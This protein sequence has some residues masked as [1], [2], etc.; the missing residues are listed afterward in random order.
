MSKIVGRDLLLF[1]HLVYCFVCKGCYCCLLCKYLAVHDRGNLGCSFWCST[2]DCPLR[3]TL[4]NLHL[5]YLWY[6][7][8]KSCSFSRDGFFQC[9]HDQQSFQRSD[10]LANE[11]RIFIC[12]FEVGLRL[13]PIHIDQKWPRKR[14]ERH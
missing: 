8:D 13:P 4:G 9:F 10:L 11:A 14:C 6:M 12:L 7:L 5:V 3:S 2:S 1:F